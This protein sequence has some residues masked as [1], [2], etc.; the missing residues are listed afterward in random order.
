LNPGSCQFSFEFEN[1][2]CRISSSCD[3]QHE[4]KRAV[5][6]GLSVQ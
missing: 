1:G 5:S 4:F 2:C 6:D 3:F